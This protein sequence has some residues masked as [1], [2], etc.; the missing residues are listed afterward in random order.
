[1]TNHHSNPN[2]NNNMCKHTPIAGPTAPTPTRQQA[3]QA[4]RAIN[5]QVR[6]QYGKTHRFEAWHRFAE[7]H[8][9]VIGNGDYTKW[10]I[11][12]QNQPKEIH[13]QR[14][15]IKRVLERGDIAQDDSGYYVYWPQD[16]QGYLASHHLRWIAEHLDELNAQWDQ[17]V[18]E[19]LSQC[20]D[21]E[22]PAF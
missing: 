4:L 9:I 22:L 2:H 15:F 5:R 17:Q 11:A 7:S 1:M 21:D 13:E 3:A 12:V 14:R 19:A 16:M 8:G 6:A 10:I 18:T 20:S